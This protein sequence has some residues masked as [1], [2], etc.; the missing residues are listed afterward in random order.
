MDNNPNL[1]RKPKYKYDYTR[2]FIDA[3][4][5]TEKERRDAFREKC[6]TDVYF[7][8]RYGCG[9]PAH[10]IDMP[11][12]V[13]RCNAADKARESKNGLDR[14]LIMVFRGGY[15]SLVFNYGLNIQRMLEFPEDATCIFSV[16]KKLAVKHLKVIKGILESSVQLK[17]WFSDILYDDPENETQWNEQDGI[18]LKR[19]SNRAE[20]TLM[21]SGLVSGMPTGM[22]FNRLCYDDVVVRDSVKTPHG[23]EEA[24]EA[25]RN[26]QNL[27]VTIPTLNLERWILGTFYKYNDT[28]CQILEDDIF[29]F[30]KVPWIDEDGNYH[31]Y[32]TEEAEI[33][34]ILL[35]RYEVSTQMLLDPVPAED[36]RFDFSKIKFYNPREVKF[37][38][39]RMFLMADV[40]TMK[41][42]SRGHDKDRTAIWVLAKDNTGNEYFVDGVYDFLTRPEAVA[43]AVRLTREY[44]ISLWLWEQTAAQEDEYWIRRVRA[45]ELL[46]FRLKTFNPVTNKQDRI[47]GA[48]LSAI[49]SGLLQFP[50][51]KW[52]KPKKGKMINLIEVLHKEMDEYPEGKDDWLDCGAQRTK[53]PLCGRPLRGKGPVT[54]PKYK[55][56]SM[57]MKVG[58]RS[59]L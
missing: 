42:E 50:P 28:Y 17:D 35:G 18:V 38:S 31:I 15:K 58:L 59:Y 10:V 57:P 53:L 14:R 3:D 36:R 40:A 30:E 21:A 9:I 32:T 45:E 56:F 47:E 5:W 1:Y 7:L 23:I 52:Y 48:M 25:F 27:R 26:S 22:H 8:L 54:D 55:P 51:E 19:E 4:G 11:F 34:K 29:K 24:T 37:S 2:F 46:K 13:D 16:N 43:E 41:K 20:P 6:L 44:N 49:E 12:A 33:Q 39:M